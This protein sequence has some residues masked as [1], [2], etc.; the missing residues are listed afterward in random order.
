LRVTLM[1]ADYDRLGDLV[2]I[3]ASSSG[4]LVASATSSPIPIAVGQQIEGVIWDTDSA[5]SIPFRA[6]AVRV[7][8]DEGPTTRLAIQLTWIEPSAYMTYQ[9]LVYG[10]PG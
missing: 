6:R 1:G 4:L 10:Q 5:G 9:Q 2:S 8:P 7:E 3:N